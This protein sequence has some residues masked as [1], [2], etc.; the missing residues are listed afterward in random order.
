MII[1][2]AMAAGACSSGEQKPA[3]KTES[4]R[5]QVVE[6]E[7]AS[8]VELASLAVR[9]EEGTTWSFAGNRYRGVGPSHLREHMLQGLAVTVVFHVEDDVRLIDEITD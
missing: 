8:I 2:M 1:S 7:A 3:T 5:G 9:D 4:V 6:V